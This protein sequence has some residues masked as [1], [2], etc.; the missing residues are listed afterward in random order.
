VIMSLPSFLKMLL[1]HGRVRVAEFAPIDREERSLAQRELE[2][3]ESI[4]RTTLPATAPEFLGDA[5]VHAAERLYRVCQCLV[6]RDL[7]VDEVLPQTPPEPSRTAAVHYSADLV[8]RLLPD[9]WRL[10]RNIS[11]DDPLVARLLE[12][13]RAWPLSSVG[14]P[15]TAGGDLAAIVADECLLP[16]YCDRIIQTGDASRLDDSR[17]REAVQGAIGYYA[18]L[19]PKL[20]A[21]VAAG[22]RDRDPNT[23][24]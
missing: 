9:A 14:I 5:A 4:Y 11:Q 15:G 23:L 7:P 2:Q 6:Y 17:V 19:S 1:E 16:V 18:E 24:V 10:A 12:L 3:F 13:G 8:L 20:A 22:N 21:I